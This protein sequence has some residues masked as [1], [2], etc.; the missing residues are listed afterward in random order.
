M[1]H[2]REEFDKKHNPHMAL[3][4]APWFIDFSQGPVI[5]LCSGAGVPILRLVWQ[6]PFPHE[7]WHHQL[8]SSKKKKK[9]KQINQLLFNYL[10]FLFSM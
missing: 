9:K 10:Y 5:P 4:H 8:Y 3:Q 6:V 7:P 1:V 2:I